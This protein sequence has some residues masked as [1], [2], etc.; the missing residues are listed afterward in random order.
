[1]KNSIY[2]S[3]AG[4]LLIIFTNSIYGQYVPKVLQPDN[5]E[6]KHLAERISDNG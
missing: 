3:I 2:F 1:M 6:I 5:Q 4:L